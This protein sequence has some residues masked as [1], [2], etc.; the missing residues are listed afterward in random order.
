MDSSFTEDMSYQVIIVDW[1][2]Y[3]FGLV[4]HNFGTW[5]FDVCAQGG[6]GRNGSCV[7]VPSRLET[8]SRLCHRQLT[9][10]QYRQL[11]NLQPNM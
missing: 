10:P 6:E 3:I 11:K 9:F 8:K 2:H 5:L 4:L 1:V 7:G